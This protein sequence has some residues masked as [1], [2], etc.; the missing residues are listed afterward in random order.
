MTRVSFLAGACLLVAACGGSGESDL[1]AACTGMLENDPEVEE[2]LSEDGHTVAEYCSCYASAAA[3]KSEADR[4]TI[5]K[6]TQT[7]ADLRSEKRIGLE[8]AAELV[9]RDEA[10]SAHGVSAGEFELTGAYVEAVRSSILN[11]NG[12]CAASG[13]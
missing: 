5:L 9:A 1:A 4:A 13:S 8:A 10:G 7:L 3:E 2:D 6:V 11:G 12:I